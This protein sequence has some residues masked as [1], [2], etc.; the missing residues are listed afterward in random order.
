M[1]LISGGRGLISLS[2]R[3]SH[4]LLLL[5]LIHLLTLFAPGFLEAST[6]VDIHA[7]QTNLPNSP[8]LGQTVTTTG[9]V[10]A[11]LSDGF[12][13]ENS[14]MDSDICTAEGIYVFT[15]G[16]VPS[17]A[18]LQNSLTVTGVVEA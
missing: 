16:G 3:R 10:I 8:Y 12:Y 1:Q 9:I 13:I 4:Q 5:L 14:T 11:V 18:V 6:T 15:P 2:G 17:N 7:I